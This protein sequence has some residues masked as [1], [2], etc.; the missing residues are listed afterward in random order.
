MSLMI[1]CLMSVEIFRKVGGDPAVK[2][3]SVGKLAL[4]PGEGVIVVR[5]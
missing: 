5:Y 1:P 4:F 3:G 2:C